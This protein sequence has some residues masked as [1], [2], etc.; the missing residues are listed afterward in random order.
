MPKFSEK[1]RIVLKSCHPD[2][3]RLFNEVIKYSVPN[4]TLFFETWV[5]HEEGKA[6]NCDLDRDKAKTIK[7]IKQN[8]SLMLDAGGVR[9]WRKL[10]SF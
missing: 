5:N 6:T 4:K 3:Q 2:L 8:F 1:S 10:L 7:L 9:I